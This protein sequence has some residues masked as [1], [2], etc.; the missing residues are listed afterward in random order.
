MFCVQKVNDPEKG[1]KAVVSGEM[2]K[3]GGDVAISSQ[4]KTILPHSKKL[5]CVGIFAFLGIILLIVMFFPKNKDIYIP[6]VYNASIDLNDKLVDIE[7]TVDEE[8]IKSI[9]MVNCD[10]AVSTM[11]P[12]IKPT[13]EELVSQICESQSLEGIAYSEESKYTAMVLLDAIKEALQKAEK[14]SGSAGEN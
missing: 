11:Y 14:A 13:F 1:K 7:V 9:R 4:S 5:I 12:L 10:E 3:E 8:T 6:G 2:K